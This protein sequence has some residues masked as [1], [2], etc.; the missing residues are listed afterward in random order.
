MWFNFSILFLVCHSRCRNRHR[1]FSF[2]FGLVKFLVVAV[3]CYCLFVVVVV[4]FNAQFD[5]S[6]WR[7]NW[8]Q[9]KKRN[10]VKT[11]YDS[12]TLVNETA[13]NKWHFGL[14]ISFFATC[15]FETIATSCILQMRVRK[16]HEFDYGKKW[17]IIKAQ[18]RLNHIVITL[19]ANRLFI[20][21]CEEIKTVSSHAVVRCAFT[22]RIWIKRVRFIVSYVFAH[23]HAHP[24]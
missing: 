19:Q 15:D 8:Q 17:H 13:T 5:F 2:G 24:F 22:A 16:S 1:S 10:E 7:K 14:D 3:V 23:A 18:C 4:C 6:L 12:P 20:Y 11:E 21:F 9:Q